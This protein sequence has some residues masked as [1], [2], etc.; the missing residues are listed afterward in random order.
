MQYD[1]VD[2]KPCAEA[3]LATMVARRSIRGYLDQPVPLEVVERLLAAASHAP[4]GNNTQPW[5]VHVVTGTAKCKL[6]EAVMAE[7]TEGAI[8]PSPSYR[9]SPER[10]PEPYLSRRRAV[11][12][13]LYGRLGIARGDHAA[14]SAWHDRNFDFFN[15]PVGMILTVDRRLGLGAMIDVGM[16][17]QNFMLGA[18]AAGLATCPQAAWA[19][20]HEMLTRVLG[21]KADEVVL[22]GIALGFEDP[23]AVQNQLHTSRVPIADFTTFHS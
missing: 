12:W 20:Y 16:V 4:S 15:A 22:F 3:V 21:L 7:R 5:R 9:Y 23:S 1:L 14:A 11:G 17:A 13:E 6:T 19:S 2:E 8:E 18:A 10:W